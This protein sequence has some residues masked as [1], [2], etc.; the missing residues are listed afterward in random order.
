M[1]SIQIKGLD[2]VVAAYTNREVAPW[3]LWQG[4]QFMFKYEGEDINEGASQLEQTLQMLAQSSNAIYTLKVYEEL[5]KGGKIKNNTPDDGSFNFKLNLD[6]QEIT[7]NQ[8]STMNNRNE[9]LQRLAAI[10][11]KLSNDEEEEEEQP[12]DYGLGMIGTILT[13][14]TIQ[15]I[16]TQFMLGIL[17]KILPAGSQP[18]ANQPPAAAINGIDED[19]VIEQAIETLQQHDDKLAEHLQKL[20]AMAEQNPQGFKFL[21]QTLDNI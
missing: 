20:A 1:S 13:H 16:A 11:E 7:A 15:P 8:Y 6:S 18:P 19:N 10:E 12:Q 2:N 3:S 9:V 17:S 4:K 21:L 14:P 5:G